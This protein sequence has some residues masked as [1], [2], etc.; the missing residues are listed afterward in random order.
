M[1]NRLVREFERFRHRH[2]LEASMAACALISMA[3]RRVSLSEQIALDD[4]L[5][6]V[7]ELRLFDPHKAVDLHRSF[8]AAL[9]RNPVIGKRRALE[10]L[11]RF[12][13]DA[14]AAA[15]LVRLSVAIAVSG[16]GS[17][18]AERDT[19]TEICGALGVSRDE[20]SPW[21]EALG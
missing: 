7:A 13:G 3:D 17:S 8:V 16:S 6:K 11:G 1:K 2:F 19:L 18:D 15:L 12:A 5:E 10:A 9:Q 21:V 4:C 20:A 14:S